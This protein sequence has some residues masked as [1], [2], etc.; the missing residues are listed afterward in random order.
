MYD[1]PSTV[2]FD[3]YSYIREKYSINGRLTS[4]I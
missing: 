1:N 4:I 3:L 2:Q